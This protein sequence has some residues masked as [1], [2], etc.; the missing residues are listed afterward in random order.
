MSLASVLRKVASAQIGKYGR[1]ITVYKKA[2]SQYNVDEGNVTAPTE[3]PYTL[4][5]IVSKPSAGA[6]KGSNQVE[7]KT[8]TVEASRQL[9]LS[10]SAMDAVGYV[11]AQQDR[12]VI[13]GEDGD[14][15]VDGSEPYETQGIF[16][17]F[18]VRVVRA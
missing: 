10:A 8:S 5:A 3:T 9:L 6:Q 2:G 16:V 18:D 17:G 15:F 11:L 13:S 4:K 12:V 14:W 1:S 7:A